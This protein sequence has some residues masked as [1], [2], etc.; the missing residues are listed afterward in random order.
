MTDRSF[1][2]LVLFLLSFSSCQGPT[3]PQNDKPTQTIQLATNQEPN[4]NYV[5]KVP[6]GWSIRDTTMKDGLRIRFFLPP[7]SLN[8]DYLSGN[9][10]IASMEGRNISD[11]T[12]RNMN[13]LKSNMSGITILE[14][15]NIDSSVYNGQW[16]TYTNEQNGV[17]GDMINY[18]IPLN[19]F[20]YMITCGT[21][22]G[23]MNKYRGIFDK[24]AR[25]FKG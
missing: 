6:K 11:F 18:I 20:A 13:Y 1:S 19:G 24:I 17:T 7:Q 21:T 2:I 10:L 16:F 3:T 15:G 4:Y 5:I 9:V 22:K 12:T 23:H 8:A 14:R 25:S